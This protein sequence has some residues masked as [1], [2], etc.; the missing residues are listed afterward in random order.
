[1]TKVKQDVVISYILNLNYLLL[2]NEIISMI[3]TLT[4]KKRKIECLL[5]WKID[6]ETNLNDDIIR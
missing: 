6:K 5:K 1:V 2:V 4:C 3:G